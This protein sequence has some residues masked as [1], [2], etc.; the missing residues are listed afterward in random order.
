MVDFPAGVF[1]ERIEACGKAIGG[2]GAVL[3]VV[4]SV[5]EVADAV[6][7]VKFVFSVGEFVEDVLQG[8]WEAAVGF[9]LGVEVTDNCLVS[10]PVVVRYC[11]SS[12]LPV[13]LIG[14][15]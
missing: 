6:A 10:F 14:T 12:T 2:C 3:D 5:A 11:H 13:C 9:R 1:E 8:G 15:I 7:E 4:R